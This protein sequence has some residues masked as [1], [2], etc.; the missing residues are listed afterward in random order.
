VRLIEEEAVGDGVFEL[1]GELGGSETDVEGEQYGAGPGD[2]VHSDGV[3]SAVLRQEA[4]EVAGAYALG[5]KTGCGG[6][7]SGVK[8]FVGELGVVGDQSEVVR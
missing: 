5:S 7:D 3:L 4:D 8:G 6:I 1:P 2:G